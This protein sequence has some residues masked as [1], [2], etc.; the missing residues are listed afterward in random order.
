MV[1][2]KVN[3]HWLVTTHINLDKLSRTFNLGRSDFANFRNYL[4]HI[5]SAGPPPTLEILIKD[6][7]IQTHFV[8]G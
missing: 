4:S 6:A 5:K 2:D 3:E 7:E 8:N 1:S